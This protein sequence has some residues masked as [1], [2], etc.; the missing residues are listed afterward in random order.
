MISFNRSQALFYA[1]SVYYVYYVYENLFVR[2][3]Y[4]R[5]SLMDELI[6]AGLVG[7]AA[8]SGAPRRDVSV[9]FRVALIGAA[10]FLAASILSTQFSHVPHFP[11]ISAM[12]SGLII[13]LKPFAAFFAIYFILHGSREWRGLRVLM[14]TLAAIAAVNS[15]F[16]LRD[17]AVGGVNMH[18]TQLQ[19]RAG[20]PLGTGLFHHKV[21]S[22]QMT[23]LGFASALGFAFFQPGARSL[24]LAFA[25]LAVWLGGITIAHL[26]VKE[27]FAVALIG[28]LAPMGLS[29]LRPS[30]KVFGV[31]CVFAAGGVAIAVGPPSIRDS[32]T[33]RLAIYTTDEK[34][35][36]TV[37]ARSY[38]AA[39]EIAS[40]NFPLGVG[41]GTFLSAPSRAPV[42]SPI[43]HQ[44]GISRLDGGT[45]DNPIYLLDTFWPKIVGESGWLGFL[46]YGAFVIALAGASVR[47][48]L[49]DQGGASV[50]S[51]SVLSAAIVSSIG[52][53]IMPN[54]RFAV[55]IGLAGALAVLGCE[56][57]AH[58]LTAPGSAA[59]GAMVRPRSF[60]AQ[61][62]PAPSAQG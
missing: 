12:R 40:D 26:S 58:G 23:L 36:L 8:I 37:R 7:L 35:E 16:V 1:L 57:R 30:A 10:T 50:L 48:W 18:G 11:K 3:L 32:I 33:S 27:I 4:K 5:T 39:A 17:I 15:L 6:I 34:T 14:A 41:P 2:T 56:M 29:S 47:W 60:G 59:R 38:T 52:D 55:M 25:A 51:F 61:S 54:E 28:L 22:V 49:A 42:F 53:S 24:R 31:V 9:W 20:V 13:D 62:V 44:Y 43:Y 46:G 21:E 19:M 45:P